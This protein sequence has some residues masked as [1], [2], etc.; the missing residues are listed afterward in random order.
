MS[1]HGV[2]GHS[3]QSYAGLAGLVGLAGGEAAHIVISDGRLLAFKVYS[4]L[5]GSTKH[6]GM[7]RVPSLQV[8]ATG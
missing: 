5:P 8:L 7:G 4:T 6:S 3:V 2:S 1:V